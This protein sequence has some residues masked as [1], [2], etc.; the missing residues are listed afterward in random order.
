MSRTRPVGDKPN[1][2][3]PRRP[4]ETNQPCTAC[5]RFDECK[6][7]RLAC[8]EFARWLLNGS[9][10]KTTSEPTKHIYEDIYVNFK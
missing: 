1:L 9:A 8:R 2:Y 3:I 6:K 5:D 4:V 10:Q 7:N